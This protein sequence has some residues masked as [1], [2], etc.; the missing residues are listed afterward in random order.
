MP[1]TAGRVTVG[2]RVST[3]DRLHFYPAPMT[4]PIQAAACAARAAVVPQQNRPA[5]RDEFSA[6]SAL[7]ETSRCVMKRSPMWNSSMRDIRFLWRSSLPDTRRV[8]NLNPFAALLDEARQVIRESRRASRLCSVG[9]KMTKISGN[10]SRSE[11]KTANDEHRNGKVEA[12]GNPL[13][14]PEM[15]EVTW[16]PQ[17]I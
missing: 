16:K 8:R 15:G 4:L 13:R 6:T 14:L 5:A 3:A 7:N 17:R 10:R 1:T 2:G 12:S 9:R 11:D